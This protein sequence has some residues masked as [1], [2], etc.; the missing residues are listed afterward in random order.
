VVGSVAAAALVRLERAHAACAGAFA[1][2]AMAG[3]RRRAIALALAGG[4]HRATALAL[5]GGAFA[6]LRRGR[7]PVLRQGR[8]GVAT[9]YS[10]HCAAEQLASWQQFDFGAMS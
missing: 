9:H 4:R 2:L 6:A 10:R 3:G 1:V 7:R 5:A 8:Q